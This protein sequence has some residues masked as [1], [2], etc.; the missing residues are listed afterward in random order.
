MS[1][2]HT[3]ILIDLQFSSI[4]RLTA[5]NLILWRF[6]NVDDDDDNITTP[7]RREG[8]ITLLLLLLLRSRKWHYLFIW[9]CLIQ[10]TFGIYFFLWYV[11]HSNLF[12]NLHVTWSTHSMT[13]QTHGKGNYTCELYSSLMCL[14]G[15]GS[16]T[17]STRTCSVGLLQSKWWIGILY[18][19]LTQQFKFT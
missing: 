11:R 9:I 15:R 13:V 14:L 3:W 2:V 12:V 5:T 19:F 17:G 10:V 7:S 16:A 6:M 1:P 4:H 8:I 18:R